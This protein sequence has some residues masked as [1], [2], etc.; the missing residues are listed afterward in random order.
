MLFRSEVVFEEGVT[1]IGNYAFYN[2]KS[3]KTITIPDSVLSIGNNAFYHCDSLNNITLPDSIKSIGPYAFM[4]CGNLTSIIVPDLVK[5]IYWYTF[6]G[7]SKL[8]SII[9]PDSVTA[10]ESNAFYG[11]KKLDNIVIPETVTSI[12]N[13]AFDSCTSLKSIIIPNSVTSIGD[14]AFY[15]CTSLTNATIPASV[16]SI[17]TGAF[18]TCISLSDISVSKDNKYYSSIEG[19]LF[20]KDATE[21][22]SGYPK[23]YAA[24]PYNVP[25]SVNKIADDAFLY[26]TSLKSIIIPNSVTNIGTRAFNGCSNLTDVT[27]PES[28]TSIGSRVFSGCTNLSKL[29]IGS[30]VKAINEYAFEN[31][32]SLSSIIVSASVTKIS[33]YAFS[34]CKNIHDVYYT[35]SKEDWTKISV[36]KNN[37]YLTD[38]SFHYYSNGPVQSRKDGKISRL[39]VSVYQSKNGRYIAAKGANVSCNNREYYSVGSDGS[40]VISDFDSGT[41]TVTQEGYIPRT[42]SYE[43][44]KES[45]KVYLEQ[46]SDE[47]PVIYAV[48]ID[49]TD[50][51][52]DPYAL[53][54]VETKSTTVKAE[55]DWGTNTQKSLYLWQTGRSLEFS[56]DTLTA[57][58]SDTF[59]TSDDIVLIATDSADRSDEREVMIQN[60]T[61]NKVM[62]ALDGAEF[63][64]DDKIKFTLP[65]NVEPS[66]LAGME[67]GAGIETLIPITISADSGKV[68]VAIGL[69]LVSYEN[70]TSTITSTAT[71]NKVH[72]VTRETKNFIQKFKDTGII[73][74]KDITRNYQKLKNLQNTY[75]NALRY[76][77]GKFG[78]E[79]N[80]TVM[81]FAEGTFDTNGN[82]TWLDSGVDRKSVV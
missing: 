40:V 69:D 5:T 8:E 6:Y 31:C 78:V 63:A 13:H 4:Y 3:L 52:H 25:N 35:G 23:G 1:N 34:N 66:W 61:V 73:D 75:R 71:G 79:A 44:L 45:H 47:K 80:F 55:V 38:A 32:I 36:G 59:D 51:L 9:L 12:G 81:G 56:G 28:V 72:K 7:C 53:S 57:V 41:V 49:N 17:G 14:S 65:D 16:T 64:F 22:I 42:L 2:C 20:N 70:K 60:A 82:I 21:L 77:K 30:S 27:I 33:N 19:V 11:C 18:S 48:W 10:I 29:T 58:I 15:Y 46:K 62:G 43:Q 54:S 74:S 37:T 67:I 24:D 26:C 50:I 68:Y 76:P 39:R